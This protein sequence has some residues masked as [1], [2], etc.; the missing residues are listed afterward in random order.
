MSGQSNIS[1][2]S[3]PLFIIISPTVPGNEVNLKQ[4]KEVNKEQKIRKERGHQ[5][6]SVAGGMEG[7][8]KGRTGEKG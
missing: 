4:L 2:I 5:S 8:S 7:K 1:L 6:G 3:L